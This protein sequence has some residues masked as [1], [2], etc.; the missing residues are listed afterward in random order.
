MALLKLKGL[1]YLAPHGVYDHERIT[2]NLF[3]VDILLEYDTMAAAATDDV[4]RSIDYSRLADIA[5]SIMNGKPVNL[6]ETLAFRIGDRILRDFG[7]ID[8]LTVKIRKYN[9]GLGTPVDYS[10]ITHSWKRP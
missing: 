2:G 9:P 8:E 10:E 4:A 6:I 1:R 3:E 7:T 5:G